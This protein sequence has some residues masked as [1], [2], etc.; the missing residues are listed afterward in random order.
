MFH[1]H[2]SDYKVKIRVPKYCIEHSGLVDYIKISNRLSGYN[3]TH[4][5]SSESSDRLLFEKI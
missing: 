2:F 1:D 5:F 4:Y 3:F